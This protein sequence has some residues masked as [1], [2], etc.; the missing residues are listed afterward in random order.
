MESSQDGTIVARSLHHLCPAHVILPNGELHV[1]SIRQ[2]DENHQFNCHVLVRPTGQ[3]L[4]SSSSGRIILLPSSDSTAS[5][6][7]VPPVIVESVAKV[8]VWHGLEALIPCVFYGHPKSSPYLTFHL[9]FFVPVFSII[10]NLRQA[11]GWYRSQTA[12]Y[13]NFLLPLIL[14]PQQ[15]SN[16]NGPAHRPASCVTG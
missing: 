14:P 8:S 9:F 6:I 13:G 11:G 15:P 5:R 12:H 4:T 1:L 2:G 10:F 16:S 7:A 3:I